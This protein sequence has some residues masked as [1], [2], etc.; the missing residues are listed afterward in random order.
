MTDESEDHEADYGPQLGMQFAASVDPESTPHDLSGVSATVQNALLDWVH[1]HSRVLLYAKVH[2]EK[3]TRESF[4]AQT[5][6][7]TN[8][9]IQIRNAYELASFVLSK[10]LTKLTDR[11]SKATVRAV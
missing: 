4:V 7:E 10:N 8:A 3:S 11:A 5:V 1:V 6:T 2:T 9:Y